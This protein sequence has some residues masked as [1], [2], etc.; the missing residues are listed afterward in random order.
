MVRHNFTR[1]IS[2]C[3]LLGLMDTRGKKVSG[4]TILR[5]I[6]L[7][8]ERGNGLGGG[9]AVYG[10]YP[11]YKDY[12]AFHLLLDD[13]DAKKR[14]E[15]YLKEYFHIELAEA[16]PT[17]PPDERY[18]GETAGKSLEENV[19]PMIPPLLWRY[20]CKP[21]PPRLA[22]EQLSAEDYVVAAVMHVNEKID[23]A[24]V[25]SSG[26][27]MAVFKGVGYPEDLGH[28]FRIQD[29]EGYLWA[30]HARF[31]TNSQAWWGGAHPFTLLD[32][33]VIH[34][35]EI[36]SY[37]I[38]KRYLE[39]YG[40]RCTLMTD[41]EVMTYMLDLLMRRH[42]L[43]VELALK[44]IAAPFWKDIDRMK[45][46]DGD[47]YRALRMVYGSA[48][49]NGP[50]AIIFCDSRRMVGLND[51]IKL[52]PMVAAVKGDKVYLGSEEAGI[53]EMCPQ[54]ERLW[55]PRAGQPVIAEI[56]K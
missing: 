33:S 48:L 42:G 25:V 13:D 29:Y 20:F 51:R 27:N 21:K 28:F 43:P 26:R 52:R 35:G 8:H 14:L 5:G 53:R 7:M 1:D 22:L 56:K 40:Y 6:A 11:K 31:P 36:S 50:F 12:F 34:N 16:I 30:A 39:M 49:V 54:P 18:P 46:G 10:C 2:G 41:T 4:E 44:V 23:G 32:Y 15:E 24:F 38:N 3:A 45:D 9:F 37:G 19:A 47:L 55:N 17:R